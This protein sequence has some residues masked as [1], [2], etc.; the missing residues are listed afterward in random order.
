MTE[1]TSRNVKRYLR[2]VARRVS[3]QAALDE[4][5]L[6]FVN[7]QKALSGGQLAQAERILKAGENPYDFKIVVREKSCL[8]GSTGHATEPGSSQTDGY[9]DVIKN[10]GREHRAE[11]GAQ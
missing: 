10:M 3:L 7:A 6:E 9:M 5:R 8:A 11:G 2:A 4:A 1:V